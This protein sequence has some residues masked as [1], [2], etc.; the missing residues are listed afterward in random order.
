MKFSHFLYGSV[1]V[2]PLFLFSCKKEKQN[3]LPPTGTTT[4]DN[5]NNGGQG[6]AMTMDQVFDML[7]LR[8]KKVYIQATET[9]TFFGNSGTRY[10]VPAYALAKPD[11]SLV[12]GQVEVEVCEYLHVGDMIFSQVLPMSNGETLLSGGEFEIIARKDGEVLHLIE[13]TRLEVNI[14][15]DGTP[16]PEMTLFRG[17]VTGNAQKHTK[18]TWRSVAPVLDSNKVKNNIVFVKGS[19]TLTL[20]SDSLTLCN[21]DRFMK[22][23]HYKHFAVTV[24]VAGGVAL[25]DSPN[26]YGY[27]FYDNKKAIWPMTHFSNGAFH[28]NH[29]PDIPVHFVVFTIINGDFYA[30]MY[31]VTPDDSKVYPLTLTK[32]DPA[33]FKKALN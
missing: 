5:N 6:S 1:V 11:G 19:D 3:V 10:T 30:G 26:I 24:N 4:T 29:V 25:P 7:R 16:D 8:S 27:A 12:K 14:P 15:Q 33:D 31:A 32:V 28:E 21:A 20:F 22:Q 2:L 9:S 23:P 13:N 18:V 17:N